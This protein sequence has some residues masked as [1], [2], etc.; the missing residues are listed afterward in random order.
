M[1]TYDTVHSIVKED[2]AAKHPLPSFLHET[3]KTFNRSHVYY[4]AYKMAGIY[5]KA[6][7][8]PAHGHPAAY[9]AA[10]HLAADL[11]TIGSYAVNLALV[12]HI[13]QRLL[14][15]YRS[16]SKAYQAYTS[17]VRWQYPVYPSLQYEKESKNKQKIL[18]PSL[19]STWKIQIVAFFRQI[20][21]V[22]RCALD[23]F[24]QAFKLAMILR[25]AQLLIEGDTQA[26]FEACTELVAEWD[27]FV[28]QLNEDKQRLLEEL[29]K[30]GA[31]ADRILTKVGA[32]KNIRFVVDTFKD[33]FKDLLKPDGVIDNFIEAGKEG[34]DILNVPGK[35]NLLAINLD[36][37]NVDPPLLPPS[38]YPPWGGKQVEVEVAQA[39][40]NNENEGINLRAAIKK[41]TKKLLN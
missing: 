11:T 4:R 23:V 27:E 7:K 34:M 28:I 17:A 24:W 15:E 39:E 26:H 20:G 2:I 38:R 1:S 16:L 37:G 30:R 13:A 35:A 40:D 21:K 36:D 14:V 18:S 25:D 6:A 8:S 31:L 33:A 5:S 3:V 19:Y 9:G 32:E 22:C 12:A 10:L 29:E 41:I